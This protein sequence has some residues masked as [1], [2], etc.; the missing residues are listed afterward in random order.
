MSSRQVLLSL[1]ANLGN[2]VETLDNA[3]RLIST[4]ILQNVQ[5]STLYKTAPVGFTNQPPFVNAAVV[6][7]TEMNPTEIHRA[8]K[9][10]ETMLGRTQRERWHEREIDIDVILID[11]LVIDSIDVQI[12]HPRFHERLF[13]LTPACELIPD[14]ICPI[15]GKT[16]AQLLDECPDTVSCPVQ[17]TNSTTGS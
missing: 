9:Q 16:L 6:G 12:P 3:I 15:T 8:C 10:L 7:T 5:A 2:P 14:V 17:L 11:D 1:G 13:V 4:S